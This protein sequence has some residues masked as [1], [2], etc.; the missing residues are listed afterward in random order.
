MA[1]DHK[2][3]IQQRKFFGEVFKTFEDIENKL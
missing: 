1:K 2:L 3:A